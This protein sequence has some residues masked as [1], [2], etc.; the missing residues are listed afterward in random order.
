MTD[1]GLTEIHTVNPS[2]H[3]PGHAGTFLLIKLKSESEIG[4]GLIIK[5]PFNR[6]VAIYI[7]FVQVS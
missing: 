3:L 2:H 7:V 6:N 1:D 5:K 4:V